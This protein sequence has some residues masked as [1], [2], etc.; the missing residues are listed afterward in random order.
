MSG[1]AHISLETKLASALLAL[2]H[3]SYA[4]AKQMS[5]RHILSLYQWHHN[6]PHAEGGGDVFWNLQPELIAAHREKT[7]TV[8]VPRI[9]KNKRLSAKHEE[10][11]RRLLAKEPGVSVRPPSRWPKRGFAR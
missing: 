7:A 9:A 3:V 1:R 10:F 11:R 8:D 4:H 2:G 5:A 6:I